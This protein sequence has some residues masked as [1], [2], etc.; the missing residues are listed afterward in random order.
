MAKRGMAAEALAIAAIG[1]FVAG[2]FGTTILLFAAPFFAELG[3]RF[4]PPEYVW[5]MVFGLTGVASFSGE[6]LSKGFVSVALGA[7]LA[8]VGLDPVSGYQRLTFGW[9]PLIGGLELVSLFMGLFGVSEI[10][11]S[12]AEGG[13]AVFIGKMD[14]WWPP[15]KNLFPGFWAIVRGTLVGFFPGMLPGIS[16]SLT[17]FWAYD[18]EKRISKTPE[19]FGQGAIQGVASPESANNASSQA[20]FIPLLCF[21]IPTSATTAIIL[22]ALMV[23]G[24][25]P[26]PLLFE[27]HAH[28][29][30]AIIGSM[31]VGNVML[32]VLN[33]PLVG[34]WAKLTLVPYKILGPMVLGFCFIGSYS[35]RNSMFDVAICMLSGIL[36]FVMKKRGWPA[37][38]LVL[39]FLL[40][41]ALERSLRQS[42]GISGGNI[43]ILVQSPIAKGIAIT[44]LVLLTIAIYS[45]VKRKKKNASDKVGA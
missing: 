37:I 26:G 10:V 33:L 15:V 36:G 1:S 30:W 44:N 11:G 43:G 22:A 35:V 3:L 27:R 18:L 6:S 5:L 4:G 34:I 17:S 38:A 29:T 25:Q 40:A 41:D 31:Y 13:K 19:K 16:P 45:E 9:S 8:S 23:Q 24:L 14:R 32:L 20:G 28:L 12:L 39:G 21:G 7:L 2:T 42:L